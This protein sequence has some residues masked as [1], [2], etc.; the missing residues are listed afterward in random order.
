MVIYSNL[1]ALKTA[2]EALRF[3]LLLQVFFRYNAAI[4]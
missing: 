3:S 4:I 2:L 1:G